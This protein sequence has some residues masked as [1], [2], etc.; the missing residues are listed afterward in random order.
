[1][2]KNDMIITIQS[3]LH[4]CAINLCRVVSMQRFCMNNLR[5]T[6]FDHFVLKIRIDMQKKALKMPVNTF[7]TCT[8]N[9][10]I[11]I[12]QSNLRETINLPRVDVL[13]MSVCKRRSTTGLLFCTFWIHCFC[14]S[15]V[16]IDLSSGSM[17]INSA[18][19]AAISSS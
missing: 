14:P 16:S 4:L 18:L 15:V 2:L 1:M 9:L 7:Q 17:A 5:A 10:L 19:T 13:S 3:I 8:R 12:I 6:I 11:D